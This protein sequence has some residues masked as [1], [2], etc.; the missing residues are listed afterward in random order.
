MSLVVFTYLFQTTFV[1]DEVSNIIKEVTFSVAVKLVVCVIWSS[2]TSYILFMNQLINL[3]S[4]IIYVP[5]RLVSFTV[6]LYVIIVK[7]WHLNDDLF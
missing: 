3:T 4:V 5:Y 1:V 2:S 7:V 6:C